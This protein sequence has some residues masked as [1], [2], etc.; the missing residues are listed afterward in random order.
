MLKYLVSFVP[1]FSHIAADII[2]YI[3]LNI[4]IIAYIVADIVLNIDIV[5]Y[6]WP[7]K[8]E[9]KTNSSRDMG[10]IQRVEFC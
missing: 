5:A 8:K 4:D 10:K 1:F 3:V 7:I 6:I 2:A 9:D